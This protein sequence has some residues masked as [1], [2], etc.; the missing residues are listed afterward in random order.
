MGSA[1]LRSKLA[2]ACAVAFVSGGRALGSCR[3]CSVL[4]GLVRRSLAPPGVRLEEDEEGVGCRGG[5]ASIGDDGTVLMV[6]ALALAGGEACMLAGRL[7]GFYIRDGSTMSVQ[8]P[9][10]SGERKV[11]ECERR[12]GHRRSEA[13]MKDWVDWAGSPFVGAYPLPHSNLLRA[14]TANSS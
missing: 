7:V 3:V 5:G 9:V 11:F 6:M 2:A 12:V 1:I 13:W 4:A 10:N 14:R 8:S